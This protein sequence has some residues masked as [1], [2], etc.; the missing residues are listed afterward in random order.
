MSATLEKSNHILYHKKSLGNGDLSSQITKKLKNQSKHSKNLKNQMKKMQETM[1]DFDYKLATKKNHKKNNKNTLKSNIEKVSE[2][3]K[4]LNKKLNS[5]K[6][7]KNNPN[8]F[9][10]KHKKLPNTLQEIDENI[11]LAKL[12]LKNPEK[13]TI[14]E[15]IYIASFNDKE[16]KLFIEYLRMKDRE[17]KWQGNG[18]GSG[19]YY[20][21]FISIYRKYGSNENERFSSLRKFLKLNY[22]NYLSK[23][24]NKN[25][26]NNKNIF[27]FNDEFNA[28]NLNP[29]DLNQTNDTDFKNYEKQ[30]KEMLNQ[31]DNFTKILNDN[32][33]EIYMNKFKNTNEIINNELDRNYNKLKED[34]E[35]LEK[36]KENPFSNI[37]EI[38]QNYI[39]NRNKKF[40]DEKNL[41][42]KKIYD[43]IN[44]MNLTYLEFAK[45]FENLNEK[46]KIFIDECEKKFVDLKILT[47]DE[48]KQICFIL[49]KYN[50]EIITPEIFANFIENLCKEYENKNHIKRKST[51]LFIEAESETAENAINILNEDDDFDPYNNNYEMTNVFDPTSKLKQ[52]LKGKYLQEFE[53]IMKNKSATTINRI[54]K[55]YLKR[56]EIKSERIYIYILAKRIC[57]LFRKNYQIRMNQKEIAARKIT[58]LIKKNYWHKMD[59]KNTNNFVS[60]WIKD[61]DFISMQNKKNLAATTIQI[62]FHKYKI[63]KNKNYL[64]KEILKSKICMFC[65]NNNVEFL[66]KDCDENHY[67]ERCFKKY[68]LRGNK[69]NHNY[70][71][72]QENIKDK[73]K[74]LRPIIIEKRSRIKQYL[75]YNKINLFNHLSMWDFNNNGTIT[76]NNLKDAIN[77]KGFIDDSEI[78][79]LILDYSLN[80][81][82]GSCDINNNPV[83]LLKFCYDFV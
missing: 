51:N 81:A 41:L 68:H 47:N 39:N 40:D 56:K 80:Y 73:Y 4:I 18:L 30:G 61:K 66:C 62:A 2:N 52:E 57:K 29:D 21:G 38:Y 70:I 77:M 83:I 11:E 12:L 71:I 33:D 8:N 48:S 75:D 46:N 74:K 53:N 17:L 59:M 60:R 67:C 34:L 13:M 69:R 25:N 72:I 76:Y 55:G 16:F 45:R 35:N 42:N 82:V 14:E 44:N 64:D 50:G 9:F 28:D 32:K 26:N 5:T 54:A 10:T 20:E 3:Q 31:L 1:S 6:F 24:N 27:K 22:N 63:N 43:Y 79:K 78:K 15:K 23:E 7:N 37:D 65:K 19:H 58:Y 49:K 36:L